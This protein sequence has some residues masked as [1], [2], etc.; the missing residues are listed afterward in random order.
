MN[1][2]IGGEFSI[3]PALIDLQKQNNTETD[4]SYSSGR[5]AL[6]AILADISEISGGTQTVILPDYLCDCITKTVIEAGWNYIFY[7]VKA[8][9]RIDAASLGKIS[10]PAKSV[11]LLID[12]FGVI[13]LNDDID[14]IRKHYKESFVIADCSQS[15][16]KKD[17]IGADY[18]FTSL[19]KWFPCPDG[20]TVTKNI[21][22]KMTNIVFNENNWA[23]YK[24]SGNLLKEYKGFVDDSVTLEM[25]SKGEE[26]L[27][28]N[29]L[30]PSSEASRVIY[31]SLDLKKISEIRMQNARCLHNELIKLGIKHLYS[32]TDVQ[33]FVPIFV[34]NRDELR[35]EFFANNIF[36]PK[37]WPYNN[38]RL[39]HPNDLYD[40]ELSLICDQRYGE[41]EMQRQ[42]NV[43]KKFVERNRG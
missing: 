39:N 4:I 32:G 11:F 42:I 2:I 24:F 41:K 14:F 1:T 43:L 28:K 20:G 23:Q 36:A 29:Y 18:S 38:D 40:T 7:H 17:M 9:L 10:I 6:F 37:H 22:G 35:R 15:F 16:Y 30:C 26:I 33:L 8:N 5:C 31:N 27:D 13:N 12:Y 3:N 34:N 19:R 25:L 21:S